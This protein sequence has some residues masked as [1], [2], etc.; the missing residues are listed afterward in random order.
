[1]KNYTETRGLGARYYLKELKRKEYSRRGT[2]NAENR[3]IE[4]EFDCTIIDTLYN[5]AFYG[6]QN[7]HCI[8]EINKTK[9]RLYIEEICAISEMYTYTDKDIEN[10]E[11]Y[12]GKKMISKYIGILYEISNYE[13]FLECYF[14]DRYF[15]DMLR[16][17]NR[18]PHID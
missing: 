7:R 13:D 12:T 4:E 15:R 3:T 8:I 9:E 2:W 5:G 10:A 11:I 6:K 17:V 16:Y 1:M 18:N 14:Q